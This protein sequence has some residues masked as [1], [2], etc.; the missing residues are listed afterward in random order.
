MVVGRFAVRVFK[1][2]PWLEASSGKMALSRPAH[3]QGLRKPLGARCSYRFQIYNNK[4]IEDT[5]ANC[6]D[7][8]L[9][10]NKAF[11]QNPIR[12]LHGVVYD[13]ICQ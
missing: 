10:Q 13:A 1:P 9:E 8:H 11:R 3:Q 2:F 12:L 5:Q 7:L 6:R 4:V